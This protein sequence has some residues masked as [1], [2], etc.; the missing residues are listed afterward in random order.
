[1]GHLK[2]FCWAAGNTT[3]LQYYTQGRL[4]CV[5]GFGARVDGSAKWALELHTWTI[6]LELCR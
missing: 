2:Q 5:D 1:M 6:S 4:T 3:A